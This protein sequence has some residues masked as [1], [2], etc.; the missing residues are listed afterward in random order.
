MPRVC[1]MR[2]ARASSGNSY[3]RDTE[4]DYSSRGH[5]R[6]GGDN[7]V[8]REKD[9]KGRTQPGFGRERCS[10]PSPGMSPSEKGG[11]K[12]ADLQHP[13]HGRVVWIAACVQAPV[14]RPFD[15]PRVP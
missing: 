15:P 5:K 12:N 10:V 2:N 14:R 3:L 9:T 13:A 11:R 4:I 7:V 8:I 1:G 6:D